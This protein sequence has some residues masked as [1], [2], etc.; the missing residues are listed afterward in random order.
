MAPEQLSGGEVTAR[1]DIYSLGLVLYEIFTG[2]RALDGK[3][4]AELIHKREQSGIVP[5]TTIVKSL[6]PKI[7]RRSC[8]ASSRRP[9]SGRRPRS[10]SP[11]RCPAAI[12][13]PRRWP[14]AKRRRRRW[15]RR[16]ATPKPFT[17]PSASGSSR[18]IVAG[19]LVYAGLRGP[20][21]ALRAGADAAIAR[22]AGRS[23]PGDRR[24][25]R[26]SREARRHRARA[27]DR[28]RIPSP[29][30]GHEPVA[31]IGGTNWRAVP[32]ASWSSGIA[33]APRCSCRSARPGRRRFYNPPHGDRRDDENG[34]R[35]RGTAA[36]VRG[37]AAARRRAARAR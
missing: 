36:R 12:R 31:R 20:A 7:E 22:F 32:R 15:W 28:Q 21:D 8:A 34:A 9:T 27:A 30:R 5:P 10:R 17:P 25:T 6:D 33:R 24:V 29:H 3:N 35:R 18:P 14:P 2:Q 4:L 37:G 16:R 11:P 23:R 1:S 19:L 13:W 26:V